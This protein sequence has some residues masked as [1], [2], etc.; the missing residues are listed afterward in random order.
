MSGQRI[1]SVRTYLLVW[2]SLLV[3][4]LAAI[5]SSYVPMGAFNIVISFLIAV[6]K[7]FLVLIFFMHLKH[8]SYLTR[9]F[10][11][12]GFFWLLLLFGLTMSD[13][14]TRLKPLS[15]EEITYLYQARPRSSSEALSP[16]EK[17]S[18]VEQPAIN[19]SSGEQVYKKTCSAC[20]DTGTLGAPKIGNE[21]AWK[22]RIQKGLDTLVFHAVNGFRAMP[23][24]GGDPKLTQGE[25]RNGV[26]YILTHSGIELASE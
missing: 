21:E 2:I 6:G 20:H 3:L 15:S 5:G 16:L 14:S 23:P 12:A 10:A 18:K 9:I 19:R 26:I 11:A 24:K 7:A 22:S 13:Y 4:L 17:T 25:V 1:I 8:S